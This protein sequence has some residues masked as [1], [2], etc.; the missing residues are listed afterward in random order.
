M[1]VDECDV[2]F[3]FGLTPADSFEGN[4]L[5]FCGMLGSVSHRRLLAW[6]VDQLHSYVQEMPRG[7]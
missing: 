6:G 1:H 4:D 2:T 5:A 7:H 3:N